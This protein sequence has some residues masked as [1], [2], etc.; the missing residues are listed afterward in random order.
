MNVVSF[1]FARG[2]SR[3]IK[4]KNLLKFK[5]TTLLGN[6][7]LQSKKSRYIK[8]IFVS[9]DSNKIAKE[10]IKNNAEVP[11]IRPKYLAKANSPEIYAWRHAINFLN[12]KLNLYP[13]YIVSVP[14]TCPLRMVSDIDKCINKAIKN[15]LDVV[16]ATTPSSRNPYFNMLQERKGKLNIFS[17]TGLAWNFKNKKIYRRQDAP[18]CFDL[19][20]ACYVFKPKYIQKTLDLFS[21]KVG[22]VLIPRERSIDIDDKLD[23]KMV[24]LLAKF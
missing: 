24:N 1:I 19:S 7:I 22:F 3:G 21:G 16:F 4:S 15:K 6:S 18:K 12:K 17:K 5:K 13:D 2:G 11:F 14:T 8:R 23:Y 9:T 10:A 20:T